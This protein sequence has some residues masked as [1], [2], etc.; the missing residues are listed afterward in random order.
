MA[1]EAGDAR[2][3]RFVFSEALL[4]WKRRRTSRPR[5]ARWIRPKRVSVQLAHAIDRLSQEP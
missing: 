5:D 4:L 2:A 3:S 1:G